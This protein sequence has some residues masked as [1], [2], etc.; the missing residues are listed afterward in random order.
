MRY[1]RLLGDED[2]EKGLGENHLTT[3]TEGIAEGIECS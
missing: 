2:I 1:K 3:Q